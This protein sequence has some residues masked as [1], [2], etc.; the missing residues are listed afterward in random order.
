MVSNLQKKYSFFIIVSACL[1]GTLGIYVNILEKYGF[2]PI[3]ISALRYIFSA[4]LIILIASKYGFKR[5][6]VQKNDIWKFIFLGTVSTM[7]T[8]ILYLLCMQ[9]TSAAVSNVLMYT[10]PI[11]VTLFLTVFKGAKFTKGYFLS[12]LFVF[13]GCILVSN[14]LNIKSIHYS[15]LGILIGI[16]SGITYGS[17]TIMGKNLSERYSVT[18]IIAYNCL[19]AGI[20]SMFFID[21]KKAACIIMK[22][23][24]CFVNALALSILGT[25]IPYFLYSIALK[26]TDSVKA[27]IICTAEPVTATII[28]TFIL[29]E[30]LNF[31]QFLGIL[32][33]IGTIILLNSNSIFTIVKHIIKR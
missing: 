6:K 24:E 21:I 15:L 11:W 30:K 26:K 17:Y 8:S 14:V 18:A 2:S 28:S 13:I 3:E 31:I 33:I 10:S 5:L 32:L 29:D 20:G 27:S 16:A 7:S 1:W 22:S 23:S 12:I 9:M 19:F 25:V 4:I